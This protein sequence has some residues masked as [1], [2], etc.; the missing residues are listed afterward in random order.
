MSDSG[1]SVVPESAAGPGSSGEGGMAAPP[2]ACDCH[3]HVFDP[4]RFP[5][6]RA[7]TYTPGPARVEDLRRYLG[8]LGLERVV[9]VQPSV[10]GTDNACL[11]AALAALGPRTARGVAVV[12]PHAAT[13]D[14]LSRLYDAGVRGLRVNL[15]SRGERSP[16]AA[17]TAIAAVAKRAAGHGFAVQVYADLALVAGLADDLSRLPAPLVLDHFGGARAEQGAEGRGLRALTDLLAAGNTWVKL[18][19]VYR[20]SRRGAPY[21]DVRPLA[22]ALIAAN[23]DRVVWASDWPHTGGGRERAS[24]GP[25]EIEPFQHID[26]AHVLGLLATWAGGPELHRRILVANAARL[27]G[28]DGARA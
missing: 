9:L 1:R 27:F 8:G 20:V 2:G 3:V 24:R 17:R 15:E 18:S 21:E 6:D 10:Y 13:E 12:D 28:F 19:G 11:V 25:G 14:E 4:D 7:R 16:E 5:Y 22:E 23:P 26:D